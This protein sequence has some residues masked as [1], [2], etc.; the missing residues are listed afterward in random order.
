MAGEENASG[1]GTGELVVVGVDGSAPSVAALRWAAQYGAATGATIRAVR[2]WHYP[3]AV[4]PSAPGR[5]PAAVTEKVL[6]EMQGVLDEALAQVYPGG[7]PASVQTRLANGHAAEA[8]LEEAADASLLVV[9][10]KGH[11]ALAG[12]LLGSVSLHCVTHATCPVLVVR[13]R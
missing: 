3:A 4:G 6:A 10:N 8:L 1:P 11:G 7:P 5:A 2:A 13:G 9:G 12:V